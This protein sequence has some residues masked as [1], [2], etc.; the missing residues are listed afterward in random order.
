MAP[1]RIDQILG[2]I[3]DA[4]DLKA[5]DISAGAIFDKVAKLA[6]HLADRA[7]ACIV[8]VLRDRYFPIG[9]HG[10]SGW[11]KKI[12]APSRDINSLP[13]LLDVPDGDAFFGIEGEHI[14]DD[15]KEFKPSSM[16]F[17]ALGSEGARF[18]ALLVFDFEK[19]GALSPE[20][21]DELMLVGQLVSHLIEVNS[22]MRMLKMDLDQLLD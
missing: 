21:K 6:A 15:G 7:E 11:F 18:G 2:E 1:T 10:D 19:K 22:S 3:S 5:L 13:S 4:K 17:V 16:T 20:V 12:Q 9:R 8:L 14:Y